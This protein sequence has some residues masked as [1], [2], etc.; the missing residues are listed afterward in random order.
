MDFI[1]DKDDLVSIKDKLS[2]LLTGRLLPSIVFQNKFNY[3]LFSDFDILF[4]KMFFDGFKKYLRKTEQYEFLFYVADPDPENYFFF[5]FGFYNILKGDVDT[6][7][8]LFQST[9]NIDP[10]GS[11]ADAIIHNTNLVYIFSNN[12]SCVIFGDRKNEISVLGLA[13]KK[14]LIDFLSSFDLTKLEF[15]S[16]NDIVEINKGTMFRDEVIP[17]EYEIFFSELIKNYSAYPNLKWEK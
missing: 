6:N 17:K 4:S 9:I 13:N 14:E 15:V 3:V 1:R 12:Q 5:H 11:P 8:E 10:G 2:N 16:V 7:Y